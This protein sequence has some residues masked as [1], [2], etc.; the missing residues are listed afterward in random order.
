[1]NGPELG[2]MTENGLVLADTMENGL[3]LADE[4]CDQGLKDAGKVSCTGSCAS[5][6]DLS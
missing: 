5:S 4:T 2:E 3:P 6:F 1:M